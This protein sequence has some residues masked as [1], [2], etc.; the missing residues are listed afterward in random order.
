MPSAVLRMAPMGA[1]FGNG[2][3]GS[4]PVEPGPGMILRCVPAPLATSGALVL[5]GA[6]QDIPNDGANPLELVLA[7]PNPDLRYHLEIGIPLENGGAL[8]YN[9]TLSYSAA[10]TDSL[11]VQSAFVDQST[12]NT[13]DFAQLQAT[14][15]NNFVT[16]KSIPILGRDFVGAAAVQSGDQALTIRA[17]A[18]GSN[19]PVI[20]AGSANRWAH[21]CETL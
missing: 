6:F 16:W 1:P 9:A 15:V 18:L 2:D 20:R 12:L 3:G 4:V 8:A 17:T 11:G 5:T 13:L 10:R 21:F 14:V 7:N 19:G